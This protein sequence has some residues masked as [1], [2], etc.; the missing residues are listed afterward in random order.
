MPHYL[1]D[2]ELKR[3]ALWQ[4]LLGRP[5]SASGRLCHADEAHG[6]GDRCRRALML[7]ILLRPTG[8]HC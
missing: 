5:A 2:D 8:G 1:S 6:R 4:R 3:T 7:P